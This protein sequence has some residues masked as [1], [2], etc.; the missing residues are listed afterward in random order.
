MMKCL[1]CRV[2]ETVS[3]SIFRDVEENNLHLKLYKRDTYIVYQAWYEATRYKMYVS[4]NIEA[5]S[6]NHCCSGKAI[7]I[8]YFWEGVCGFR[9]P[10]CKDHAPCFTA[11]PYFSTSSHK[12]YDFG[13]KN[14]LNMKYVFRS[15][16]RLLSETF[17]IVR[18]I[19]RYITVNVH[20]PSCKVPVLFVRF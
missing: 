19:Q 12:R 9:F 2:S 10:V 7:N 20:R 5:L 18:R 1:T 16:L 8:A 6:R 13:E 14:W 3:A 11:V 4:R 15:S 17:V